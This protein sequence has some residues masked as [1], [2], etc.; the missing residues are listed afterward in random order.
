MKEVYIIGGGNSVNEIDKSKL[1][2][3]DLIVVNKGIIDFPNPKFFITIDHSF[4]KKLDK[5][6]R[7][8]R[9]TTATK[10]FVANF[11][12]DYMVEKD[13]QIKD[14]RFNL[15][16][17]LNIFD[18]IIKSYKLDGLGF[19]FNNFSHGN[20][21]AYC[22]LQLAIILGYKEINLIGI[23]LVAEGKTHYHGGYG[24]AIDKFQIKLDRY[25]QT[26]RHAIIRLLLLDTD[27]K[28]YSCSSI[29]RLNKILEYKD[30]S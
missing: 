8:L 2:G 5:N 16:Y 3:K 24:E 22:A 30:L 11:V 20:N 15:V 28:I 25:Y 21:S 12:P 10:I 9:N 19:E 7:I 4:L 23:D 6:S 17:K 27:I 1:E 18:M 14:T 29:S 13:G 26:Y